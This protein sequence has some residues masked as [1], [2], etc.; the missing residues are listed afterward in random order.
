MG[1]EWQ[2]TPVP[3]EMRDRAEAERT[4]MIETLAERDD[5]LM[6]DYLEGKPISEERLKAAIRQAT[7]DIELTPVLCG[8]SFK[9]KG[10]QMLLDA[11][12]DY[13]PSPLDIP[14]VEG[15]NPRNGADHHP[16]RRR[17]RAL[18][19]HRF[20][21]HVRPLR[22]Q[23]HLLP[24]VLG[25]AQGG[26][27]RVQRQQGQEGAGRPH[28]ADARQPSRGHHRRCSRA[29]SPRRWASRP[30]PPATRCAT[31]AA[32]SSWSPSSSP[33]RSSSWPSSPRPRPTR[34]GSPRAS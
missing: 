34:T 28:P 7:L 1:V 32:P 33:S 17:R 24:G 12:V 29:T 10:V 15:I 4:H 30:P 23:A 3:E 2:E 25:H 9:N 11:V 16:E 31:T 21:D 22:G 18:L 19:G 8:S 20:Q 27:L 5:E 14:P 13:L 26:L 6:M